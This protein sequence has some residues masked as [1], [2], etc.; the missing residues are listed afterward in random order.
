MQQQITT[1]RFQWLSECRDSL[2]RTANIRQLWVKWRQLETYY[3]LILYMVGHY[4]AAAIQSYDVPICR[5]SSSWRRFHVHSRK[6]SSFRLCNKTLSLERTLRM[7]SVCLAFK[8]DCPHPPFQPP[9][10]WAE[11]ST[12]W[13]P[14]RFLFLYLQKCDRRGKKSIF[15][16]K[17]LLSELFG[18]H[19]VITM[20]IKVFMLVDSF[21]SI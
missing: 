15:D 14:G 19:Q 4:Q 3:L 10:S 2:L 13:S 21:H 9:L 5:A 12:Q 1:L 6:S 20:D 18:H 7:V 16:I 17:I 11:S 8:R